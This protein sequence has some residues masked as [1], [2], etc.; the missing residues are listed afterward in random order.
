MSQP[1]RLMAIAFALILQSRAA[2]ANDVVRL[3]IQK[4]GTVAWELDI[5]QSRGLAKAAGLDLQ[6][7]TLATPEALKIALLGGK[8]DIIVS[9]WLFV[10]RE[11]AMGKKLKFYPFSSAVGAVM[12]PSNSS[13]ATIQDL[14]GRKLAVAGGPID[15]SWLLTQAY[16]KKS[17]IDLKTQ[18]QVL[19]GAPPLLQQKA[20][21]GEADAILNYWNFSAALRAHKFRTLLTMAQVETTLGAKAPVAMLGYAFS[22]DFAKSHHAALN[23]FLKMT[24]QAKQ[25]LAS[26]PQVWAQ[27][28][29]KIGAPDAAAQAIFQAKYSAGIPH[30]PILDEEKDA[31]VL[32]Q[33]LADTGGARLVGPAPKLDPG[34]FYL[35]GPGS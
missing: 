25:I 13:I 1:F 2:L 21:Q 3:A 26:S 22:S 10:S 8:A 33:V 20:L 7:E 5:A 12:V 4:T 17:G 31:Q 28:G 9:D 35:Q 32:Y 19:F 27:I 24:A 6:I 15:K 23:R 14:K 29:P 34:T 11:R 16:A 18:T 30:R